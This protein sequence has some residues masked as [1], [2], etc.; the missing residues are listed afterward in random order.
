MVS[1]DAPVSSNLT[2]C[3]TVE[4]FQKIGALVAGVLCEQV[5][6]VEHLRI[7]SA[8]GLD[9]IEP[10]SDDNADWARDLA[11]AIKAD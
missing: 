10:D 9:G 6:L 3:S 8:Q 2:S 4:S 11:E 7:L 5:D 1:E